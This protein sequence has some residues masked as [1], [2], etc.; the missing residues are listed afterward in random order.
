MAER[1]W[2]GQPI[3]SYKNKDAMVPCA[4]CCGLMNM[5]ASAWYDTK[6]GL[7]RHYGCLSQQR[8]DEIKVSLEKGRQAAGMVA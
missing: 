5:H 3:V 2:T 6:D 8:L 1:I 7:Y 4:R